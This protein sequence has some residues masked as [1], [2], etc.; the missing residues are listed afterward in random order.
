MAAKFYAA[1]LLLDGPGG[2]AGDGQDGSP[3]RP[4]ESGRPARARPRPLPALCRG[5]RHVLR[6]T[7]QHVATDF[8]FT[9]RE[10]DKKT[11]KEKKGGG[12][13]SGSDRMQG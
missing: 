13:S 8:S 6:G 7:A 2:Y 10:T 11:K 5:A 1:C 9:G 3:V 12:G 4:A